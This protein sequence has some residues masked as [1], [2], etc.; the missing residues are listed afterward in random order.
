VDYAYDG[1]DDASLETKLQAFMYQVKVFGN[2][3]PVARF[4]EKITAG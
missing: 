2:A 1:Q 4:S 3:I